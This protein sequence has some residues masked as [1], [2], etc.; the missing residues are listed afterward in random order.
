VDILT[1]DVDVDL[2]SCTWR[3]NIYHNQG[4]P[5]NVTFVE[6][7]GNLPTAAGGPLRGTH[8]IAVFDIDGDTWPDLVIG[9]CNGTTVWI[10]QPP[11]PADINADGVVNVLDLIELLLCFGQPANPPCDIADVN[12]DNTVNVLDLIQLLLA[13]GQ[14]CP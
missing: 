11:C 4:N 2:P 8:D 6:D 10:N 5:P 1:A 14:S 7:V 3:V 9:T 12:G 13:F